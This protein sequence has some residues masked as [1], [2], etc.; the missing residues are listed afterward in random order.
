MPIIPVPTHGAK[1][2]TNSPKIGPSRYVD[3]SDMGGLTQFGAF[4]E[5]LPRGSK[6][7]IKHWHETEDEFIYMLSGTVIL[8]EG[9]TETPFSAGECA[10]FKAGVALGH[11]LENRSTADA[12][13]L[14][15]GTRSA[16]DVITYPEDDCVTIYDRATE[17]RRY[18]TLDG[19][20]RG[21]A[22]D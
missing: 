11:C 13:Y 19:K 8:H 12:T 1:A 10:T 16:A 18:H 21:S 5:T 4:T 20:P 22:Y 17:T 2:A 14:V 9:D 7:S 3:Y 6:S 15:V